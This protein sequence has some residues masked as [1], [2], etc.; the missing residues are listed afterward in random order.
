[1][2]CEEAAA[3]RFE[4]VAAAAA[5]AED[6]WVT[7]QRQRNEADAAAYGWSTAQRAQARRELRVRQAE[8]RR[9]GELHG[10][11]GLTLLPALRAQLAARGWLTHRWRNIP[12]GEGFGRPWGAPDQGFL[13]KVIL[14]LPDD[15]ARIVLCGSYWSSL[16]H[17]RR[18][19]AWTDRNSASRA[20]LSQPQLE[21]KRQLAAKVVT[22]HDVLRQAI[23][24]TC[25]TAPPKLEVM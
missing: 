6:L 8:L 15:I 19:Q 23:W 22:A 17:V 10:T 5:Q 13:G 24:D 3:Q 21:T 9:T 4:V 7:E 1:V 20:P 16:P 12:A 2:R 25:E 18:L 11:N 14:Q